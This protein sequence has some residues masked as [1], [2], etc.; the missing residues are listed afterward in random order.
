MPIVT[1]LLSGAPDDALAAGVAADLHRLTVERLG[2]DPALVAIA[3]RFV[4]P[5]HW[6]VAGR[7]LREHGRRSAFVDIRI[8]DETNTRDEK[9][10]FVAGTYDALGARLGP[11]HEESYVHVH[12]VRAEAYGYGGRTQASRYHS[13]AG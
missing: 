12:D 10:A 6:F 1:V 13:A 3:V 11:M 2:K 5:A 4:D 8:T 7:T 9:A